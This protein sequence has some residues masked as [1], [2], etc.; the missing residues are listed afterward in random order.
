M[1]M[2]F[3]EVLSSFVVGSYVF[4][5]AIFVLSHAD[6]SINHNTVNASF[7]RNLEEKKLR[8]WIEFKLKGWCRTMAPHHVVSVSWLLRV[9]CVRLEPGIA[10]RGQGQSLHNWDPRAKQT[11]CSPSK[12]FY[13]LFVC[14]TTTLKL[15]LTC[16]TLWIPCMIGS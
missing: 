13:A 3:L 11:I 7:R 1:L 9:V 5:S 4:C 15:H 14:W 8:L 2:F 12:L 10:P 6:M 16:C